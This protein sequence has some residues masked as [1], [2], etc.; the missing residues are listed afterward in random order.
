MRWFTSITILFSL[1]LCGCPAKNDGGPSEATDAKS[2]L[3]VDGP[4]RVL[5]VDDEPLAAI[6][7]REWR[8]RSE[9]DLEMKSLGQSQLLEQLDGGMKRLDT[10]VVIFPPFM[11]GELVERKLLRMIPAELTSEPEYRNTDIFG[12]VRRRELKWDRQTHAVAFGSP[13]LVLLRRTDL[14]PAAPKTWGELQSELNRLSEDASSDVAPIAQPLA[15]GWASRMLLVRAAP[16]FFDSSRFS[17]VFEYAT[18]QPTIATPPFQ[19]ALDE[20]AESV[21]AGT[22]TDLTPDTVLREFLDGKAAMAITWLSAAA[23][24]S[25]SVADFPVAVSPLPSVDVRYRRQDEEWSELEEDESAD[26][27]VL[28]MDGRLGGVSRSAK[29]AGL[30]NVF[31]A[32]ATGPEQT[33]KLAPR[34]LNTGPSRRSHEKGSQS[35]VNSELPN[36]ISTD[37]F[38]VVSDAFGRSTAIHFPRLPGQA[39]YVAALD[40]AVKS[41]IAGEQTSEQA[42]SDARERWQ[43]LTE[44]LGLDRQKA[45]YRKSLGVS[46]N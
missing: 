46:V 4:L 2:E 37:Y 17:T 36:E 33:A 18:M 23:S 3:K 1:M 30:A 43:S 24:E 25:D 11:L 26:V 5:V 12:L 45:A 10:D 27:T 40:K 15:E 16:Y 39:K 32:W 29:N 31:L 35:W 20:L 34:S 22:R 44:Q 14:V 42:L 13:T 8:A 21:T 38:N 7:D 6:L 41:G 19:R 9:H 28:G